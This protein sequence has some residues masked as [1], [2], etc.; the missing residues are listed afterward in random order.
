MNKKYWI[1]VYFNQDVPDQKNK[2]GVWYS[3]ITR[4]RPSPKGIIKTLSSLIK[5][6]Y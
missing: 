2:L 1:S 4:P 3:H 6:M 5:N